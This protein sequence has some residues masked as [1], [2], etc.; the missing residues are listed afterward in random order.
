M[1]ERRYDRGIALLATLLAVSLMTLLVVEF[2]TSA[3]LGYRAAANQANELRA[4]YLARSG[5]QIGLAI[6]VQDYLIN[7]Q[8]KVQYASLDQVWAQPAM[9]IRV[10]GGT[11]SVS[12]VD[13]ERKLAI[14]N[15]FNQQKLEPDPQFAAVLTRLL[16]NIGLSPALIPILIDWLD[17]DSITSDG[18]AEADYYLHLIPPYEPRNG[19]MPT[20]GD[21]RMLKGMDDATFLRLSN[22]LTAMQTGARECCI[23]ANTASPE[24]L[25]ALTPE[26]ESDSDTV[27]Q[28]V[29]VRSI[30]PFTQVT[31][32]LNLSGL[33]TGA[34]QLKSFVSVNSYFFLITA[35]GEFAGAR[36][37]IYA[38]FRRN[39][40]GTAL[41]MNWHED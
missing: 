37:R 5:I 3:A 19:P 22:F 31:D 27:K 2:S 1:T 16:A 41:L 13:E 14:N 21:L 7:S 9:P 6:L 23:N 39:Q 32:L 17:P 36:K 33:G 28:I 10:D 30:R 35:Q 8:S 25:A 18:G 40:N 11:V 4:Y 20:T 24:V 29:D 34:E 38:T 15:L 12:I 26:L